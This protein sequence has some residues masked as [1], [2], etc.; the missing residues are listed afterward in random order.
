MEARINVYLPLKPHYL[1]LPIFGYSSKGLPA[2]EIKGPKKN[3]D[4]IRE[5]IIYLVR[6]FKIPIPNRRFVL[7]LDHLN[8]NEH[9]GKINLA[10]PSFSQQL[11][12][13]ELP[14]LILFFQL[15]G[16][17]NIHHLEQCL[18]GGQFN[19]AGRVFCL[20]LTS[21]FL[22]QQKESDKAWVYL[23]AREQMKNSDELKLER[24]VFLPEILKK[25]PSLTFQ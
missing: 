12:Y 7:V 18:I 8:I 15:A 21:E 2:L 23:V 9:F 25:I 19:L 16:V 1:I 10:H 17:I 6:A 14:F 13:L 20:N 11:L 4:V 22:A 3:V 24:F 5:K